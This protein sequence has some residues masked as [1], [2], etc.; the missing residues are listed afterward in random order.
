MTETYLGQLGQKFIFNRI[1]GS[2]RGRCRGWRGSG[3]G[4][5]I[6]FALGLLRIFLSVGRLASRLHSDWSFSWLIIAGKQ[7]NL[8][9]VL[10]FS[11]LLLMIKIKLQSISAN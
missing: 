3:G 9:I 7:V 2:F 1:L 4:G 11:V 6:G 10:R 5:G 8:V